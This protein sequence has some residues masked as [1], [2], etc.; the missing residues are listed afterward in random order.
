MALGLK[1][2]L[3]KSLAGR[4]TSWAIYSRSSLTGTVENQEHRQEKVMDECLLNDYIE[5]VFQVEQLGLIFR[6][7][8]EEGTCLNKKLSQFAKDKESL[9]WKKRIL[10]RNVCK[11][12]IVASFH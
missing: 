5:R 1:T 8:R 4:L 3:G 11:T 2:F 7:G 6:N 9:L 12:F 10:F